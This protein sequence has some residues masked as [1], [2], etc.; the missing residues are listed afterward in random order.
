M[1]STRQFKK[2]ARKEQ[3]GSSGIVVHTSEPLYGKKQPKADES[4]QV[5]FFKS[6]CST[7]LIKTHSMST[8]YLRSK[9]WQSTAAVH[10]NQLH[11]NKTTA[12]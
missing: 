3:T 5:C 1:P 11:L 9:H 2:T 8:I 10:I 7:C 4:E 6:L 12:T